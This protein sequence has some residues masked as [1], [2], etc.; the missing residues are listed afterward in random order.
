MNNVRKLQSEKFGYNI[1]KVYDNLLTGSKPV[2]E[3][4]NST[5]KLLNL[6]LPAV[7]IK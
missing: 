2:R 5:R 4:K 7:T 1:P 3:D 6:K